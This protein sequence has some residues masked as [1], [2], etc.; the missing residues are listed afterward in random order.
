MLHQMDIYPSFRHGK[1]KNSK[2]PFWVLLFY[3]LGAK[4]NKESGQKHNKKFF[5][6]Y[7][8]F[9]WQGKTHLLLYVS[10]ICYEEYSSV[11]QWWSTRLLTD[12]LSVRAGPGE[13]KKTRVKPSLFVLYFIYKVIKVN[14][15]ILAVSKCYRQSPLCYQKWLCLV[16]SLNVAKVFANRLQKTQSHCPRELL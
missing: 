13:P 9:Y 3:V 11:A 4:K 16:L 5:Q 8:N 10:N 14:P 15:F 1:I 7:K 6:K 12:R 2:F